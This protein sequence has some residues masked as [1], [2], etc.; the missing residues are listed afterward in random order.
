MA[1][2]LK[3]G[4]VVLPLDASTA[5]RYR[6]TIEIERCDLGGKIDAGVLD[7]APSPFIDL[8]VSGVT[9]ISEPNVPAAIAMSLVAGSGKI[10]QGIKNG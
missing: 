7:G 8:E 3:P 1:D 5:Y 9:Q 6:L 10:I 4:D 2:N